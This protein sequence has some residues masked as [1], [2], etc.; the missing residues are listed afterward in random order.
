MQIMKQAEP[1]MEELADAAHLR[2]LLVMQLDPPSLKA[3]PPQ[4]WGPN[5]RQDCW[6]FSQRPHPCPL[7]LCPCCS[8]GMEGYHPTSL[9]PEPGSGLLPQGCPGRRPCHPAI[10]PLVCVPAGGR[11]PVGKD[12]GISPTPLWSLHSAWHRAGILATSAEWTFYF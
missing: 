7:S 9:A 4:T 5:Q 2:D 12:G 8:L 11:F 1:L 6:E 10:Q 3:P